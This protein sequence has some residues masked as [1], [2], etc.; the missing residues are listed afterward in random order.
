MKGLSLKQPYLNLITE[1]HKTIETRWKVT[2]YRGEVLLCS[3]KV[4]FKKWF[5][6]TMISDPIVKD[7][8][9]NALDRFEYD[10]FAPCGVAMAVATIT[11]CRL[12][13]I[14]DV[15]KAFIDYHVERHAWILE[16]VKSIEQFPILGKLWLWELEPDIL[17]SIKI[18]G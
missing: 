17:N 16:D 13:N 15:P 18:I 10:P 12:M 7:M 3:S 8:I 11:D 4:P 14:T 2:H 6:K 5:T 1:G 9:N